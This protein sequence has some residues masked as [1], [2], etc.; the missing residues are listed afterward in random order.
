VLVAR[1]CNV[2]PILFLNNAVSAVKVPLA[3]QFVVW[4]SGFRGALAFALAVTVPEWDKV[5]Q[6]GSHWAGEILAWTVGFAPGRAR[7]TRS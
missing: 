5:T 3:H 2:F 7:T 4:F 1:A 6:L